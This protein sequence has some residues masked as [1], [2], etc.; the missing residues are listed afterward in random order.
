MSIDLVALLKRMRTEL[1]Y[2]DM[3]LKGEGYATSPDLRNVIRDADKAIAALTA[4]PSSVMVP[5]E[6]TDEFKRGLNLAKK[7]VE[8]FA[9]WHPYGR[10]INPHNKLIDEIK[11]CI[12][13]AAAKEPR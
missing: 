5:V 4:Q 1:G 11:T 13:E 7:I 2:C 8:G 12:E 10:P 9:N 6:P 3:Q